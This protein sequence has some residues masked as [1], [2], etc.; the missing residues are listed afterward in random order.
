MHRL[1]VALRPPPAIRA[2]LANT[3]DGV[4]GARWQDDGQLHLTVRYIGEVE[5]RVAEDVALALAQVHAAAP[6]ITLN[7]VGAFDRRGRIN[8]LWAGV[9]P[10]D[11]LA[12]L[13]RKTDHALVR[14]GLAPEGRAYLPHITIARLGRADPLEIERWRA[15]HAGLASATFRLEHLVLY[16]SLLGSEGPRYETVM[17]WPLDG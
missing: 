17:R 7:G 10:H 5:R 12:S 1:F 3:M 6:E 8:A 14:L 9:A 4:A 13:H 15:D 16:E 11:A 2:R